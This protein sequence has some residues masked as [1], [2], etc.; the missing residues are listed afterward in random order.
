MAAP[1]VDFYLLEPS[2]AGS[3]E[4]FA[5]K[6]VEQVW[7]RGHRVHVHAGSPQEVQQLDELLW[8]WSDASF[9]PHRVVDGEAPG[10]APEPEE[11]G[12]GA[13]DRGAAVTLGCGAPPARADGVLVNLRSEVPDG[14]ERFARVAE[15]VDGAEPSRAAGRERFRVY[16]DRGC[17]LQTHR[18]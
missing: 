7:R 17:E 10:A 13:F 8:T 18:M 6:F 2:A 12:G 15:I 9:L 14:F 1:R 11:G 3:R 5:C 16:R 4:R